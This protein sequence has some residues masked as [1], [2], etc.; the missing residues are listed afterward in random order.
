MKVS[1]IIFDLDGTVV[2]D[3]RIYAKSFRKVLL[4]YGVKNPPRFPHQSGIGVAENW[5]NFRKKYHLKTEK[6]DD[7]L[8]HETQVEYAKLLP[9]VKL[10]KGFRQFMRQIRV[11]GILTALATSNNWNMVE[12]IY[13]KFG[14]DGEFDTTTTVEE[15]HSNKPDPEIFQLTVDKLNVD[16]EECL[17]IEDSQAGVDAAR[18]AGMKVIAI[19]RDKNRKK[20]LDGADLIVANFD[21]LSPQKLHS[22]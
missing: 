14:I 7:E 1:A 15:L 3:E 10:R 12:K 8:A 16:P 20:G 19:C 11:S 17:V 4:K 22:L 13:D 18:K 2:N 21:K 6:T 5:Q 9:K